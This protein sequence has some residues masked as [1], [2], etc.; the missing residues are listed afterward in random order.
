MGASWFGGEDD[1][2][3]GS[4]SGRWRGGRRIISSGFDSVYVM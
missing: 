2:W 4:R 3:F 1:E